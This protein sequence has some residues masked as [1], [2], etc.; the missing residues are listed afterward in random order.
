MSTSGL[1]SMLTPHRLLGA[2]IVAL[3]CRSAPGNRPFGADVLDELTAQ[4]L[5]GH[6]LWSTD[7]EIGEVD[8]RAFRALAAAGL[9]EVRLD[10][11]TPTGPDRL[12]AA[13]EAVHTL[14]QLQIM[15]EYD[16]D[17]F[18]PAPRF[19]SVLGRAS[20]LRALVSDGS[21]PATF[22]LP[23]GTGSPWLSAYQSRLADA[24]A[25]WLGDGGLAGRLRDAWAELTVAERLLRGVSG[26]AAHRIALQRLTMRSNTALLGLVTDSARD[27]ERYGDSDR[28]DPA[29]VS[30]RLAELDA[31]LTGLHESFLDS[32]RDIHAT[33]VY[34]HAG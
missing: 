19:S 33:E 30:A 10:L 27:F 6:V 2:T 4:G 15:V 29:V 31:G 12:R 3:D 1:T 32:N 23:A 34:R 18:G 5:L 25:P 22:R 20:F 13:M 8:A 26:S 16:F 14:S 21:T 9:I 7:C 24:V 11:G 28:L 17:L